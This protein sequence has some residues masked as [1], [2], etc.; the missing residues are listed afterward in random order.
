MSLKGFAG[1]LTNSISAKNVAKRMLNEPEVDRKPET[2]EYVKI[3]L[4]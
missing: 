2:S 1:G 3:I 4:I